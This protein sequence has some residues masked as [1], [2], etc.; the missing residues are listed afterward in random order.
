M[1]LVDPVV[2]RLKALVAEKVITSPPPRV[3][4]LVPR[5]VESDTVRVLPAAM[6][7]VL[8]PLLVMERPLRSGEVTA[9]ANVPVGTTMDVPK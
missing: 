5:V 7:R 3:I 4:A 9:V 8:V 6:F 2:S 1:T